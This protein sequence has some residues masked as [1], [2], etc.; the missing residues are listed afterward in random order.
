MI[1]ESRK[2]EYKGFLGNPDCI[3]CYF[4]DSIYR[5]KQIL[6]TM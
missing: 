3:T 6:P 1:W 4:P 2:N 5:L